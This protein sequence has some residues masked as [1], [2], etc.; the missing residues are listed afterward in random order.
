MKNHKKHCFSKALSNHFGASQTRLCRRER[1]GSCLESSHKCPTA[2]LV[3]THLKNT[4]VMFVFMFEDCKYD[5]D[6]LFL[7]VYFQEQ[8]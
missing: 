8:L 2:V 1:S 4:L 3:V 7:E 5:F 6:E